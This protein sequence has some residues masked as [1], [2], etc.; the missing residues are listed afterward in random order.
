MV[1]QYLFYFLQSNQFKGFF[2]KNTS[3]LIGGVSINKLRKIQIRLPSYEEQQKIA[4]SI[5]GI[6]ETLNDIHE[7]IEKQI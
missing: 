6:F 1:T 7:S 4:K 2:T 5:N 3:G